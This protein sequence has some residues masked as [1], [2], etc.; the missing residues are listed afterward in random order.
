M[1]EGGAEIALFAEW[2]RRGCG[3]VVDV[4]EIGAVDLLGHIVDIDFLNLAGRVLFPV[5]PGQVQDRFRE[6]AALLLVEGFYPEDTA[7]S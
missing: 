1:N 2:L 3:L 7:R 4:F 5:V 6:L